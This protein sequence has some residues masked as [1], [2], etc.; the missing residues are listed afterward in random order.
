MARGGR[1]KRLPDWAKVAILAP[2]VF[3]VALAAII[4]PEALR[5]P[6]VAITVL[7]LYASYHH[8]DIWTPV[9]PS[10]CMGQRIYAFLILKNTGQADGLVDPVLKIDGKQASDGRYLV[11]AASLVNDAYISAD[12]PD[13]FPVFYAPPDAPPPCY[14]TSCAGP[15]HTLDVVIT[16][17]VKA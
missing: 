16:S 7:R 17:V 6:R 14:A 2:V 12:L 5:Q 1:E 15:V 8:D 9:L 3:A 10:P 4:T 11:K 13:C